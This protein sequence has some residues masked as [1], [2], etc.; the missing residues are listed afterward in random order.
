MPPSFLRKKYLVVAFGGL[1]ALALVFSALPEGT[2]PS[3]S[4]VP[5]F[6]ESIPLR[7][8]V[9]PGRQERAHQ[10][11]MLR[12]AVA[13]H[14]PDVE[15]QDKWGT[16]STA[17]ATAAATQ[18]PP[19]LTPH[20]GGCI[21]AHNALLHLQDIS[22]TAAP[23]GTSTQSAPFQATR[24]EGARLIHAAARGD[25]GEVQD[26]YIVQVPATPALAP[27]PTCIVEGGVVGIAKDGVFISR[28]SAAATDADRCGVHT[29]PDATR[30]YH[31]ASPCLTDQFS[32]GQS[33][34]LVGY[35]LDGFGIYTQNAPDDDVPLDACGGHTHEIL[36]DGEKV[37][38]YHYHLTADGTSSCFSGTPAPLHRLWQR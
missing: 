28:E 25:R 29:A 15:H 27:R 34:I 12:A 36:W 13:A 38:M 21:G 3:S 18:A 2:T 7:D 35:A 10:G 31:A 17:T 6:K 11:E 19:P 14:P 5:L 24:T 32:G 20:S 1:A 26:G 22:D 16:G 8:V 9:V 23:A 4:L 37:E 30:H 33:H